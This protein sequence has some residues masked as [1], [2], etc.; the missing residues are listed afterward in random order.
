MKSGRSVAKI[1]SLIAVP[2]LAFIGVPLCEWLTVGPTGS[3]VFQEVKL[4]F[5]LAFLPFGCAT[6]VTPF[7]MVRRDLRGRAMTTFLMS[8]SCT[9]LLLVGIWVGQGVRRAAF[10]QLERRSKALV[11]AIHAH[12][13]ETGTPPHSLSD[14]VPR[15]IARVPATGMAAYPSYEFVS[16]TKAKEYSENPWALFVPTTS[17][18]LNW[19]IFL[20][21]PRQNYPREGY[22]GTLERIGDWAYVHE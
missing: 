22:G 16:G 20:Y 13:R 15:Y 4:L 18:G 21:L 17:G 7:L 3:L 5:A 6:L 12:V 9:V 11:Q 14:L 8:A 10:I 1:L 19:D 2:V